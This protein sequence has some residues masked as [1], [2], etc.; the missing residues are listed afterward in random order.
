MLHVLTNRLSGV[1]RVKCR[2]RSVVLTGDTLVFGQGGTLT[3]SSLVMTDM[4]APGG[5]LGAIRAVTVSRTLR[6]WKCCG[7]RVVDLAA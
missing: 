2:D 5:M 7:L 4:A 3:F 6:C 1:L